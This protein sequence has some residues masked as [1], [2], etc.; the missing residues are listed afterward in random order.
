MEYGSRRTIYV[1]NDSINFQV[2]EWKFIEYQILILLCSHKGDFII[3]VAACVSLVNTLLKTTA[4]DSS[5]SITAITCDL[6]ANDG[7]WHIWAVSMQCRE[8]D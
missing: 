2:V 8:N 6:S 7:S 4:I 5:Q 3:I 1:Y